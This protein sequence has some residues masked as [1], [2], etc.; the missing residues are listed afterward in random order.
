[1]TTIFANEAI[2][3]AHIADLGGLADTGAASFSNET[4][5]GLDITQG[6]IE[7]VFTGSGIG[8]IAGYPLSGTITGLDILHNGVLAYSFTDLSVSVAELE[9]LYA[10]QN[11][12][13]AF[14]ALLSGNDHITGSAFAD[15]LMGFGGNDYLNGRAGDDLLTGGP[16]SDTL[17]GGPGN[18]TLNG[19]TGSDVLNGGP[20]SDVLTGGSGADRFVFNTAPAL[21]NDTITDFTVGQDKIVLYHSVFAALPKGVLAASHFAEGAPGAAGDFIVYDAATGDLSYYAQ[22]NAGPGV[23]FATLA[24][25]AALGHAD[26]IVA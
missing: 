11:P 14:G 15:V 7:F 10:S 8:Y 12:A 19:G 1:M 17:L 9:S 21:V 23:H 24:N 5:N 6:P 13:A 20:G 18:D 2:N 25:H 16:G 22:G 26:I 4:A 3:V